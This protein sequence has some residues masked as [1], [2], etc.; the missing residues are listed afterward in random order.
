MM[1]DDAVIYLV[2]S[3]VN[4]AYQYAYYGG[5]PIPYRA[6]LQAI[7]RQ[8]VCLVCYYLGYYGCILAPDH[9]LWPG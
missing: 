3:L 1:R 9:G 2:G 6:P 7:Y 8:L 4:M 5:V